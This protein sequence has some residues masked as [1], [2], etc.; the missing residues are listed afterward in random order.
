MRRQAVDAA[1]LG[2][3]L[4]PHPSNADKPLTPLSLQPNASPLSLLLAWAF[5]SHD[6]A[7]GPPY[8]VT[9]L[10]RNTPLLAPFSRTIPRV[11][12]RI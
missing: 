10:I 5:G 1:S 11:I 3:Q 4:N 6:A 8:M 7:D 2:K 9:S 12:W